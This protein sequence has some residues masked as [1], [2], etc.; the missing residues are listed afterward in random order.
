MTTLEIRPCTA[1]DLPAVRDLM[2]QL[3]EVAHSTH[4]FRL[5]VLEKLLAD[6]AASPETYLNLVGVVESRVVAFMSLLF[7]KTLFHTGG[8]ALINELVV[9]RGFRGG[10]IGSILVHKAKEEAIARRMDE[11]EVGTERTNRLA[12]QFYRK[13]GFDQEYVLLGLEFTTP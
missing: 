8:T 5:D 3:D 4:D 2:W 11:I 1:D 12:R 10:G 7:Y 9:D 13:C 6:M